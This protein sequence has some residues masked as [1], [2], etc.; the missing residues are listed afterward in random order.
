MS[1]GADTLPASPEMDHTTQH[2]HTHTR[3]HTH[4]QTH[5]VFF[6]NTSSIQTLS[7]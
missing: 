5:T 4:T 2:T 1:H 6:F 7:Q 3:R